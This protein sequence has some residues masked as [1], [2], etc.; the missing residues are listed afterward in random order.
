M[1]FDF[2]APQLTIVLPD[3]QLR[4]TQGTVEGVLPILLRVDWGSA[5]SL[6][7]FSRDANTVG[8][9]LEPAIR[10]QLKADAGFQTDEEAFA[11]AQQIYPLGMPESPFAGP[12]S[13]RWQRGRATR[14]DIEDLARRL[15]ESGLAGSLDS[16]TEQLRARIEQLV[17]THAKQ[18][19][20]QSTAIRLDG[21]DFQHRWDDKQRLRLAVHTFSNPFS[22]ADME[23]VSAYTQG[24]PGLVRCDVCERLFVPVRAGRPSRRCPGFDC[25]DL[26]R[27]SYQQRPDRREYRRLAMRLSRAKATGKQHLIEA[28]QAEL[29]RFKEKETP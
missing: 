3:L 11:Q 22:R 18:K 1:T 6:Y 10:A 4:G 26:A 21:V 24:R 20:T 8:A 2:T 7:A 17:D 16:A 23:A 5:E 29:D 15:D 19:D 14:V 12:A 25:A 28:A 9:V 27:E 13:E